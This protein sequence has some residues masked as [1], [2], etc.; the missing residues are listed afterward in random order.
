[1]YDKLR[2][3]HEGH[4]WGIFICYLPVDFKFV[5]KYASPPFTQVTQLD[6]SGS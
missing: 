4:S 2:N 5:I 1:M 3:A 6:F